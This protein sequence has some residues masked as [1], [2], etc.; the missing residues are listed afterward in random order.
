MPVAALLA[1]KVRRC[2][3]NDY[4]DVCNNTHDRPTILCHLVE[5]CRV[6]GFTKA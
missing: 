3:L 1:E 5:S 2:D 4:L 6:L